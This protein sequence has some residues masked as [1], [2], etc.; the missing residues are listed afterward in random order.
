MEVNL[1]DNL[2]EL[3]NTYS[4]NGIMMISHAD[5]KRNI[6]RICIQNRGIKSC[7]DCMILH[8]PQNC[9]EKDVNV[10]EGVA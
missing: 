1:S 3:F 9:P 7:K 5:F 4:I 10:G 8:S 2:W 6:E